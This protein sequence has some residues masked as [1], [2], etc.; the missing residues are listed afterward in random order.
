M[1][2]YFAAAA[3]QPDI[4]VANPKKIAVNVIKTN[5]HR[6]LNRRFVSLSIRT[7]MPNE[8]IIPHT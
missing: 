2:D 7:A 6:K 5:S 3:N 8:T 1:G 4:E